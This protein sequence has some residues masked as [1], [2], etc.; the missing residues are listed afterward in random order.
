[1]ITANLNQPLRRGLSLGAAIALSA[2]LIGCNPPNS[3]TPSAAGGVPP[4][5]LPPTA[6][7][8]APGAMPAAGMP[9]QAMPAAGA[10][11]MPQG[12]APA[13]P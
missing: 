9:A 8:G 4:Q 12:A 5:P 11:A 3:P 1:M 13:A 10:P 6:A 7:S 2:G